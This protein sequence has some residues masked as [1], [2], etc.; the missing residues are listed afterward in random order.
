MTFLQCYK[1]THALNEQ[2]PCIQIVKI[3]GSVVCEAIR[4]SS[5]TESSLG[6]PMSMQQMWMSLLL[7]LVR[8]HQGHPEAREDQQSI[9]NLKEDDTMA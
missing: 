5:T 8:S 9:E 2:P 1:K 7:R 3:G 4:A 6:T